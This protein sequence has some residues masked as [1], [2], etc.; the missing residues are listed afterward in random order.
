MSELYN[1]LKS[2]PGELHLERCS[3]ECES[4][5]FKTLSSLKY[6]QQGD[7]DAFFP[8]P[9]KLL[10]AEKRILESEIK[11]AVGMEGKRVPLKPID[12]SQKFTS[13]SCISTPTNAS[14]TSFAGSSNS[15]SMSGQNTCK[16]LDRK[17]TEMKDTLLVLQVQITSASGELQKLKAQQEEFTTLSA[18]RGRICNRCHKIGH[19]K[20]TCKQMPCENTF[21]CKIREKHPEMKNKISLL[22]AELKDLQKQEEKR[23]CELESFLTARKTSSRVFLLL[24]VQDCACRTCPMSNEVLEFMSVEKIVKSS[25]YAAEMRERLL[26]DGV[27]NADDLPSASQINKSS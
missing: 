21:N 25:I 18:V 27:V 2:L 8:S 26:F 19:T 3:K 4:R 7:I 10:L 12:L 17:T 13:S 23:K 9:D 6:L 16:A 5:G 24:C 11:N 15:A 1:W 20:T 22:Q 14:V